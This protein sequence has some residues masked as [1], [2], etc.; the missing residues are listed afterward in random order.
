MRKVVVR[1]GQVEANS[2]S[3]ERLTSLLATGLQRFFERNGELT[4]QAVDLEANESVTTTCPED[5][6]SEGRTT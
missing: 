6:V 4:V 2:E 3:L 1:R 5:G